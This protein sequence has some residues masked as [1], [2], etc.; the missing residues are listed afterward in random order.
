[1]KNFTSNFRNLCIFA[2]TLAFAPVAFG[3]TYY[4]NSSIGRDTNSGTTTIKPWKTIAKVNSTKLKAGD[5]VA[6]VSG[7]VWHEQLTVSGSGTSTAPITFTSYGGSQQPI[8]DGA[9]VVTGWNLVSGNTYSAIYTGTALKGFTDALYQQTASLAAKTSL[10][11]AEATP[12]SVFS[13][14]NYVY[15]HLADNSNPSLHTIEISGKRF[16]NIVASSKSYLS[17]IGLQLVRAGRSGFLGN[18]TVD[19]SSGE[20]T[21]EN[22]TLSG[23]TVYNWGNALGSFGPDGGAGGLYVYGLSMH[24][25]KAQH[26]WTVTNNYCGLADV[27]AVLTYH[28]SCIDV[29]A[30]SGAVISQNTIAAINAMGITVAAYYNGDPCDTPLVTKNDIT[31]SQ[32]NIR[33]AGCPNAVVSLNKIHDSNGYGINLDGNEDVNY[34]GYSSNAQLLQNTI[35]NLA[36]SADGTL[37][38]GIDC[39]KGNTGGTADG[40]KISQVA[41]NN[42]TLEADTFVKGAT[43]QP[44]SGWTVKNNT[45]DASKN[46]TVNGTVGGRTGPLYIRDVAIQ[47][48]TFSNNTYIMN[49]SYPKGMSYGFTSA[50]DWSHDLTLTRF[51]ATAA[52]QGGI[53]SASIAQ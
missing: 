19:N 14:G 21:N 7:G 13:D 3:A 31:M 33:V 47:G 53:S 44:C 40:N 25:Q 18:S 5:T 23:L 49:A 43:S 29:E 2:L 17:F 36:P 50:A 51:A 22:I 37:Y 16:Y 46:T 11:A 4:V 15:V 10:T 34:P 27:P 41:G 24:N 35:S 39:N 32:G 8:I 26:G 52:D 1:M 30:T 48:L 20:L 45:F 28:V 42:M 6:F 9:D 12:G 38:N